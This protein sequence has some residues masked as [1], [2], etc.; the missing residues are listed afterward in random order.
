M[1][2][3]EFIGGSM[4]EHLLLSPERAAERLDCGRTKI[5]ALMASGQ[6]PSVTIGRLRRIP[7]EALDTYVR[8]LIA[9]SSSEARPA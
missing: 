4:S 3:A 8:G 5:Y 1:M 6:L 2:S 9:A 7:A